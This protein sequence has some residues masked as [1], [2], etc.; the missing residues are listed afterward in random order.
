MVKQSHVSRKPVLIREVL[1]TAVAWLVGLAFVTPCLEM[2]LPAMKPES[3]LMESPGS[4]SPS[5]CD[6][7]NFVDVW[8]C[9]PIWQNMKVS[10]IVA[11]AATLLIALPAA[12][13]T[14]RNRFRGRN[15][16]PLLIIITQ[17]LEALDDQGDR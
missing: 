1:L 13:H 11:G 8:K 12:Y 10:L 17:T 9:A 2:F 16:F 14:A 7:S 4:Y 5:Q 15:A 6:W 3:E